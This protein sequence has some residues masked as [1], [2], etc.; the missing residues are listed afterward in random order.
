MSA[1]ADNLPINSGGRASVAPRKLSLRRRESERQLWVG[2]CRS[3]HCE[4]QVAYAHCMRRHPANT[5][6]STW[7]S[8]SS[9][10]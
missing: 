9:K 8:E 4:V 5:G 10:I 7:V 6:R 3:Q 2:C 1:K